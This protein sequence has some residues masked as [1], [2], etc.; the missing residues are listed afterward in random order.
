MTQLPVLP[1]FATVVDEVLTPVM[2]AH[3]FALVNKQV[4]SVD[5]RR[6]QTRVSFS[7]DGRDVPRAWLSITVGLED[8]DG[9]TRSS[10][11]G[12]RSLRPIRRM[13]TPT[14][15]L[16]PKPNCAKYLRVC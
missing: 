1:F 12:G 8:P 14:G 4:W 11:C 7:Y 16:E 9:R 3:G 2:K 15:D 6:G 13:H 5:Y 10:A